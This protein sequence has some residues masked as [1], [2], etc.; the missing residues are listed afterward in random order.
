MR[1]DDLLRRDPPL[2][3]T[4][5]AGPW[6]EVGNTVAASS[7]LRKRVREDELEDMVSAVGQSFLGMTVNCARW[8]LGACN[9]WGRRRNA[10]PRSTVCSSYD[11]VHLGA[12]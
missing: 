7:A 11:Q 2:D 8:M 12:R 3:L 10:F 9:H 5:V 4:L 6:D 1:L